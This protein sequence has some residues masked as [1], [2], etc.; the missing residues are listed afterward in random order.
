MILAE[1]LEGVPGKID[2][3]VL[4]SVIVPTYRRP[5]ELKSCLQC[6]VN[7]SLHHSAY[8]VLIVDNDKEGS[9]EP[10]VK[11][12]SKGSVSLQYYKKFSNNVSEARNLGAR[13][14]KGRWLAFL[15]D[16]CLPAENWLLT[17]RKFLQAYEEPG[18]IFGGGYLREA[19]GP[20][21]TE[22]SPKV[23]PANQYLVEGN[24]FFQRAEYLDL[25]G[26][27]PDLGPNED[28][29]GYHEGAELIDRHL[30]RHGRLHRRMLC[31]QLAVNHLGANRTGRV[32]AALLSGFDSAKVFKLDRK[33]SV[34]A[35]P[36]KLMWAG[37]RCGNYFLLGKWSGLHREMYRAGEILGEMDLLGRVRF[38]TMSLFLRGF[39][40]RRITP[41]FLVPMMR[42]KKTRKADQSQS[43]RKDDPDKL[44]KFIRESRGMIWGKIGTTELLALEFSDRW[45]R[46]SWPKT[47]SWR[48]AAER[49]YIDSGVFPVTL[50]QFEDFLALYRAAI[51]LLDGVH[52]WQQEPFLA[53]YERQV[54]TSLC[55][56]AELL[57]AGNVGREVC[58][59]L[60]PYRWLVISPFVATMKKQA[61]KLA[62]IHGLPAFS[63]HFSSL[64]NTCRFL[65]S[66]QFS[67]LE[68]TPFPSW[69]EGLV[70][71]TKQALAIEF[72]V[73]LV[74]CG[75]WSL[76]LLANLKQAG[77]KGI[78]LGGETQLLFGI[79]GRRWDS[80]NIY[81]EHWVR[82]SGEETPKDF[83]RKE[84]GCYW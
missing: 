32:W 69:S 76:P 55:P 51:R 48:R 22:Q 29:F 54:S 28:R 57:T 14:A 72:D 19:P 79:K 26:M 20:D 60:A 56:R 42:W 82:P 30:A 78:H 67:Y 58:L 6:L 49:L 15:D 23:L 37:L 33:V 5:E 41:H 74:G 64:P 17:A 83:L 3:P 80:Y 31:P 11:S 12:H 81:N 77:R 66:P 50:G 75:A 8:E 39:N 70:A 4:F 71:L 45:L 35:A 84:N 47:A 73:A 62:A 61:A 27:R 44:M 18:L 1:P 34:L 65:K 59:P 46:P 38:R 40:N 24:L 9:G 2:P 13:F 52:L 68:P 36:F 63:D 53:V 21:S 25:G 43:W 16:D 10:V 7:Q